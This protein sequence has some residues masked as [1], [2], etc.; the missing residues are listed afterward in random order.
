MLIIDVPKDVQIAVF[1]D[2]HSHKEQFYKMINEIKPS[3][4]LWIASVG[5]WFDKGWNDKDA[6]EM[7]DK[8]MKFA[9]RNIGF[10]VKGNHDIKHLKAASKDELKSKKCLQWLNGCPLSYTFRFVNGSLLSVLH[11]G[12]TPTMTATDLDN[13]S[14]VA[15]I[16]SIDD[17]GKSVPYIFKTAE[18]KKIMEPARDGRIW[19][20]LYDGRFGYVISGHHSQKDGTPKFYNFSANIDSGIY[21][22][23]RLTVQ[24]FS[25]K[26]K[27]DLLFFDGEPRFKDANDFY[28]S[29]AVDEIK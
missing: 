3:E 28:K 25:E 4:K 17:K 12:L 5:D 22:T 15:Y 19:H 8:F 14:S 24:I 18:G 6:E 13:D 7:I 9:A 27:E 20:E 11:A 1:G 16:R 23:G 21:C 26:G 29:M 10:S 2:V